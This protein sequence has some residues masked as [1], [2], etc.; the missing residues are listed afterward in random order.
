[1]N[2]PDE[3]FDPDGDELE[4]ARPDWHEPGSIAEEILPKLRLLAQIHAE[5]AMREKIL[6]FLGWIPKEELEKFLVLTLDY[7]VRRTHPAFRGK[8]KTVRKVRE[9][10]VAPEGEKAPEPPP[11]EGDHSTGSPV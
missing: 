2:F 5:E 3:C 7:A 10:G 6:H 11:E 1:M 9:E 8:K 4:D